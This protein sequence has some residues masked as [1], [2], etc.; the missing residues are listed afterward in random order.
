MD[1]LLDLDTE[2][3]QEFLHFIEFWDIEENMGVLVAIMAKHMY[4]S[5]VAETL[6]KVFSNIS[7]EEDRRQALAAAG[8]VE[9]A[10]VCLAANPEDLR[11][12]YAWLSFTTYMSL[13]D[14]ILEREVRAGVPEALLRVMMAHNKDSTILRFGLLAMGN[15]AAASTEAKAYFST[16]GAFPL[17]ARIMRLNPRD[18]E[19]QLWACYAVKWLCQNNN[20]NTRRA[21]EAGLPALIVR[22]M[23]T[24]YRKAQQ[25]QQQQEQLQLQQQQQLQRQQLQAVQ[26]ALCALGNMSYACPVCQAAIYACGGLPAI[27]AVLR[28]LLVAAEAAAE[29]SEGDDDNG[30]TNDSLLISACYSVNNV[31]SGY[32]AAQAYLLRAGALADL[33]R[34]VEAYPGHPHVVENA[35]FAMSTIACNFYLSQEE[36]FRLRAVPAILRAGYVNRASLAVQ[37]ALFLVLGNISG[38]SDNVKVAVAREGGL[39][40]ALAALRAFPSSTELCARAARA[41]EFI[42]STDSNYDTYASPEL[43]ATVRAAAARHPDSLEL[44]NCTG[45]VTRTQDP[46]ILAALADGRCSASV[47]PPCTDMCPYKKGRFYC[48][49]CAR[50]QYTFFCVECSIATKSALRLCPFCS[51]HH[52]RDY[53][54]HTLVKSFMS[55]RCYCK[56]CL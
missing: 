25:L 14:A 1:V 51:K 30:D 6:M 17:I 53:P 7:L 34:V 41:I 46:A 4:T 39:D 26:H 36:F 45:S 44:R 35:F 52:L 13:N 42:L 9:A 15:I 19:V 16:S 21:G 55:R 23:S 3:L 38:D 54:G 31:A 40:A 8:A 12:V 27:L 32:Y 2:S 28:G 37:T 18:R 10:A 50:P 22:A 5:E 29:N 11:V 47:N 48:P 49:K 24:C 33:L 43:V 20:K 56:E